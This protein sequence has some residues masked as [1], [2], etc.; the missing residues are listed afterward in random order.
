MAQLP[1]PQPS[2]RQAGGKNRSECR[3]RNAEIIG[4]RWRKKSD[5]QGIE[6]VQYHDE[7]AQREGSNL[8][9]AQ[10]PIVDEG[11]HAERW[12]NGIHMPLLVT[13][14]LNKRTCTTVEMGG[15]NPLLMCFVSILDLDKKDVLQTLKTGKAAVFRKHLILVFARRFMLRSS[16]VG[17]RDA[18]RPERSFPPLGDHTESGD[19]NFVVPECLLSVPEYLG[20][21]WRE[22]GRGCNG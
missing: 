15:R 12:C 6:P 4:D 5:A 18:D 3:Q 17:I 14:A 7:P 22:G 9:T 13:F 1:S 20:P 11:S 21:G 19:L 2:G 16:R 10:W 8:E